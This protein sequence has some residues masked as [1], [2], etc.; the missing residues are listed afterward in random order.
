MKYP[1]VKQTGIKDCG[2][3]CLLMII[4]YYQGNINIEKLKL[5][6]KTSNEGTTAYDIIETAKQ[7]GFAGNGYK[8]NIDTLFS[9][10]IK[11]PC[12]AHTIIDNNYLHYVVIYKITD[13]QIIIADPSK[14]IRKLS[15]KQFNNIFNNIIIVLTP[16]KKITKQNDYQELKKIISKIFKDN[17]KY[18]FKVWYLSL[19]TILLSVILLSST[20]LSIDNIND[21]IYIKNIL[22]IYIILSILKWII[23][24]KIN[25]INI[26]LSNNID[27]LMTTN[28]YETLFYLPYQYY[29]N[30][31]TGEII[32]RINNLKIIKDTIVFI[33]SLCLLYIPLCIISSLILISINIKLFIIVFI[34][35]LIVLLIISVN[36]NKDVN[37]IEEA[38]IYQENI[39]HY[40]YTT[41]NNINYIK[42]ISIENKII[43]KFKENYKTLI[44]KISLIIYKIMNEKELISLINTITNGIIIFLGCIFINR[45]IISLSSFI[46]FYSI[47]ELIYTPL[48]YIQENTIQF[49]NTFASI[50]RLFDLNSIQ[51]PKYDNK[52]RLNG[53]IHIKRIEHKYKNKKINIQCNLTIHKGEK[54]MLTGPSGSGKTTLFNQL[55]KN[56]K[57]KNNFIYIDGIDINKINF[58]TIKNTISYQYSNEL[59][60]SDT[61]NN[62]LL[63]DD[64]DK[65]N[66]IKEICCI[67]NSSDIDDNAL[68]LSSG[69]K[70]KIL[71]ARAMLDEK[72]VYL[73]DESFSKLD[74]NNER[75]ILKN[76]F[77]YF[78][79]KTFIIISHRK[80][81]LDLFDKLVLIKDNNIEIIA[82]GG[83]NNGRNVD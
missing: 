61:I 29:C 38:L 78:N 23:N 1:F 19:M 62:N 7:L 52:S 65:I 75:K 67:E 4:K 6:S 30:N 25:K 42:G 69:E 26:I 17:K 27:Y 72:E 39:N 60:F 68:N 43:K 74:I 79:D 31:T 63:S 50:R 58:T 14:G 32:K 59:I 16:I 37:N 66:K 40:L 18:F 13:N 2:P 81:N 57:T 41:V 44:K 46:I 5:M 34:N 55:H 36:K 12:I 77:K 15:K 53:T 70:Q 35:V 21:F 48:T 49:K 56:I 11:L 33:M 80:D 45:K 28:V 20:K 9:E 54:I 22:M 8:L 24:K 47:K 51:V 73:L 3:A 76:L 83:I 10:K 71:I 82:K 64:I